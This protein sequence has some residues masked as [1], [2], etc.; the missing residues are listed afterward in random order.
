[1]AWIWSASPRLCLVWLIM[2]Q[3][4]SCK[5]SLC[6]G[7]YKNLPIILCALD[8]NSGSF[9]VN[10]TSW[11][12]GS[13]CWQPTWEALHRLGRGQGITNTKICCRLGMGSR[14]WR[15]CRTIRKGWVG[16]PGR[17]PG[18][19]KA[20]EELGWHRL[21]RR[22]RGMGAPHWIKGVVQREETK[23]EPMEACPLQR[24]RDSQSEA[25]EGMTEG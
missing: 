11:L 24:S 17:A 13:V 14:T 3:L 16:I 6:L 8:W 18:R 21:S 10:L 1:M 12:L 23:E 22:Q 4:P 19:T 25:L 7:N 2:N 15:N 9:S 5:I 20:T